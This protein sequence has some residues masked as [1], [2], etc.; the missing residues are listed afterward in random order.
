LESGALSTA[1]QAA[2]MAAS[3]MPSVSSGGG[4]GGSGLGWMIESLNQ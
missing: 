3:L 2:G 1:L 4:F